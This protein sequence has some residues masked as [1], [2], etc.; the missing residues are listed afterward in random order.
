MENF[1]T[2]E[3]CPYVLKPGMRFDKLSQLIPVCRALVEASGRGSTRF[4]P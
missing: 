4:V 1:P 3:D 2:V